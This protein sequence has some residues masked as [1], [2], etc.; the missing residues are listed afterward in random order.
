MEEGN[1]RIRATEWIS[2]IFSMASN[3]AAKTLRRNRNNETGLIVG[4]QNNN[5]SGSL[6]K[7]IA[8]DFFFSG[9]G[10][11]NRNIGKY[12]VSLLDWIRVP[13]HTD[14]NLLSSLIT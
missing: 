14:T 6:F 9:F 12:G 4:F 13:K 1:D 8:L 11:L 2:N 10:F 5:P 3:T 7:Q